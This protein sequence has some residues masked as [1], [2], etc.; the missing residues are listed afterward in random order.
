M[1]HQPF[2]YHRQLQGYIGLNPQI[3][4]WKPANTPQGVI[5][6]SIRPLSNKDYTNTTIYKHGSTRPLHTV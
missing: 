6:G 3:D 4:H 1:T 2:Y 5:P